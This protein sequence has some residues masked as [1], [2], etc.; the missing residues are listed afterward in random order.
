MCSS[1]F[2]WAQII[3]N[4]VVLFAACFPLQNPAGWPSMGRRHWCAP[5]HFWLFFLS[6]CI[7]KPWPCPSSSPTPSQLL[8][9]NA[10]P[11]GRCDTN[12]TCLAETSSCTVSHRLLPSWNNKIYHLWQTGCLSEFRDCSSFLE[13]P[14]QA[15][16]RELLSLYHLA[17]VFGDGVLDFHSFIP[18]I[19]AWLSLGVTIQKAGGCF[20]D[21]Q[22]HA[23]PQHAHFAVMNKTEEEQVMPR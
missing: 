22:V 18:H 9:H 6:F 10:A 1:L 5:H 19:R 2:L 23:G 13:H 4:N 11:Q 7:P 17:N 14:A 20:L 15:D 3:H 12:K 16:P 21:S 8:Q